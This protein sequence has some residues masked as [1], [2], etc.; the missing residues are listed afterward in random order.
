M[1]DNI[2]NNNKN[3]DDA[4]GQRITPIGPVF[5]TEP[6]TSLDFLNTEGALIPCTVYGSPAPALDWIYSDGTP[7]NDIE[8][9]LEI[10]AN[11]SL[12]FLPFVD[13][14]RLSAD[15]HNAEYRCVAS[16]TA[17]T[18]VSREVKMEAG[19]CEINQKTKAIQKQ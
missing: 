3:A 17:G 1:V 14:G 9:L 8:G 18:I 10:K 4:S 6:P 13:P 11:G 2:N 15:V 7:V 16:N 5:L 12:H 19:E